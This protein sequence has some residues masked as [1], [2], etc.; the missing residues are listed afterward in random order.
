MNTDLLESSVNHASADFLKSN[1]ASW[2]TNTIFFTSVNAFSFV[3]SR[4]VIL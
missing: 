3:L 1:N 2:A 4:L